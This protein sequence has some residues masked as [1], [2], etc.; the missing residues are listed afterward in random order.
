MY[1]GQSKF[2]GNLHALRGLA[3]TSVIFY[4]AKGMNPVIPDVGWMS[5]V[6]QFDTGVTLF[7][8]LSGFSLCLSNFSH[9]DKPGWLRAYSIKRI[10]RIIPV[11]YAFV[12]FTWL[13]HYF[14]IHYKL[15]Y[16]TV[17]FSLIPVFPVVPG[18]EQGLVWAGWTVGVELMFYMIFPI[19]LVLFRN[20]LR[21]WSAA[22]LGLIVIS[23]SLRGYV[24]PDVSP[25]FLQ[26]SFPRRAFMFVMGCTFFFAVQRSQKY[27]LERVFAM[28]M[29]ALSIFSFALWT[30]YVKGMVSF[31]HDFLMVVKTV[32]LSSFTAFAF[33]N[34]KIGKIPQ[35][36]LYN[37]VTKFLGDKSYTIYLSHPIVVSWT[38][39]LVDPIMT[40]APSNAWGFVVYSFLV[41]AIS[42]LIGAIISTLI[43]EPLYKRGRARAKKEMEAAS[44]TAN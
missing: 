24:G 40:A 18:R 1:Q 36:N 9:I 20:S 8:I 30:G 23:L 10:A 22:L 33:L 37:R 25:H 19:M 14:H 17:L 42:C 16:N 31:H 29:L 11:W 21:A 38:R 41:I 15:P 32:A 5:I 44:T 39:P 3:A 26:N 13:N 28:L 6:S 27:D 12:A 7:F 34:P 43:E 4:H 35:L 2:S